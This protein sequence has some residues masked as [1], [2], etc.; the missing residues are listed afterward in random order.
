M[1]VSVVIPA[2]NEEK[3]IGSHVRA[4]LS[5]ADARPFELEVLV[6][7]DGSSDGTAASVEALAAE[8]ARVRLVRMGRNVGKGR[9]VR[10]GL[11]AAGGDV[12]GFTD[13]DAATDIS[14]LDR[15]LP[16][17]EGGAAVAIGSRALKDDETEVQADLHRVVIGRTFNTLLRMIAGTVDRGGRPIADTQCG[18][19]W[20]TAEACEAIFQRAVAD[21]FAFDVEVLYLANRLGFPVA[22]VPVN[23]TEK[24]ESRVNLLVDPAKMLISVLAVP[25]RHRVLRAE[26]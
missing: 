17:I 4:V 12:R 5:Y 13:A 23:W 2:F 21:G 1:L 16:A 15:I 26:G 6:V 10:E 7:D 14:E 19:K 24:G 25:F 11:L 18:F 8:D 22:E 9:A 20:F 3:A